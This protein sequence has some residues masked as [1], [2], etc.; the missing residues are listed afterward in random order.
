M[1]LVLRSRMWS[2][3]IAVAALSACYRTDGIVAI[4][5]GF[6]KSFEDL[7]KPLVYRT[8]MSTQKTFEKFGIEGIVLFGGGSFPKEES[9]VAAKVSHGKWRQVPTQGV[10]MRYRIS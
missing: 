1:V 6:Q 9:I 8:W 7:E 5:W 3:A 4:L 10:V 2:I